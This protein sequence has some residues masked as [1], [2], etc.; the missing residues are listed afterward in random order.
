M[1]RKLISRIIFDFF[2]VDNILTP[3]LTNYYNFA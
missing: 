3:I 1:I 2:E